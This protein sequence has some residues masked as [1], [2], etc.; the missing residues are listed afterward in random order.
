[1]A[2]SEA[3]PE[4]EPLLIAVA[5]VEQSPV[6]SAKAYAERAATRPRVLVNCILAVLLLGGFGLSE[7]GVG[8]QVVSEWVIELGSDCWWRRADQE[9]GCERHYIPRPVALDSLTQCLPSLRALDLVLWKQYLIMIVIKPAF[10]G[11][12]DAARA[13]L[14]IVPM[15]WSGRL[16]MISVSRRHARSPIVYVLDVI[17]LAELGNEHPR[18][19]QW[20]W[21]IPPIPHVMPGFG[22]QSFFSE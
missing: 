21:T 15:A 19:Y 8:G 20:C 18:R 12:V 13:M 16:A 14:K 1:M 6:Q 9:A 3:E 5:V 17:D 11:E 10:R 22:I 2:E 7:G 4:A